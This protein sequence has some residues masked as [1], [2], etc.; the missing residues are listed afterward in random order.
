MTS[1]LLKGNL[2]TWRGK[3]QLFEYLD[4]YKQEKGY[5]LSFNFNKKKN[6]GVQEIE[7]NGKRIVEVVV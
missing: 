4:F 5:L 2:K 3:E 1:F 6:T 7:Y